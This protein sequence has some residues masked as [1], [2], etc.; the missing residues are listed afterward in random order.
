[1]TSASPASLRESAMGLAVTASGLM[2]PTAVPMVGQ[3]E[4]MASDTED[5]QAKAS[6]VV[7]VVRHG[8]TELN[9]AGV[10][11]GRLDPVSSPPR[12]SPHGSRP[13]SR[14]WPTGGR[15]ARSWSWP[16]MPSTAT[17]SP[18]SSPGE[19]RPHPPSTSVAP[20][21]PRE[22]GRVGFCG[23][24]TTFSTFTFETVRLIEEGAMNEAFR[25]ALASLVTCAPRPRPRLHPRPRLRRRCDRR[26]R[27]SAI[28][29][30]HGRSKRPRAALAAM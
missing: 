9:A 3:R 17:C 18:R 26:R 6:P 21:P 15:R 13:R 4:P 28:G 1:M 2:A 5:L 8:R 29:C 19:P 25:D 23:A 14:L 22:P 30:P 16:T 27:R 7:Y 11:R 12:R 10:L 20:G 24:Y